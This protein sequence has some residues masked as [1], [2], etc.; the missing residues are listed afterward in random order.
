MTIGRI[1]HRL[2]SLDYSNSHLDASG[3]T[4]EEESEWIELMGGYEPLTPSSKNFEPLLPLQLISLI[5]SFFPLGWREMLPGLKS[6]IQ[7]RRET[8]DRREYASKYC[9]GDQ[10]LAERWLKELAD[11]DTDDDEHF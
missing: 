5:V 4:T 8:R 10:R 1:N 9:N 7:N 11:Y 2:K 3:D 6:C